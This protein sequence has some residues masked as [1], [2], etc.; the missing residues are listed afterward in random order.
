MHL[1]KREQ[2]EII[3]DTCSSGDRVLKGIS[4]LI[5]RVSK[6]PRHIFDD[7]R[8]TVP[9]QLGTE[10]KQCL[11]PEFLEAKLGGPRRGHLEVFYKKHRTHFKVVETDTSLAFKMAYGFA[12]LSHLHDEALATRILTAASQ[13]EKEY[14]GIHPHRFDADMLAQFCQDM[15]KAQYDFD[16]RFEKNKVK[17]EHFHRS[18]GGRSAD[19]LNELMKAQHKISLGRA[20]KRFFKKAPEEYRYLLQAMY[21]DRPLNMAIAKEPEFQK[22]RRDKGERAIEDFLFDKRSESDAGRVTVI[23]SEDQGARRSIEHLRGRS[24]N[25]VFCVS[26]YGL[27]CALKD[28][29]KIDDI[30]EVITPVQLAALEARQVRRDGRRSDNSMRT[31]SDV[32]D[33]DIERKW[34]KR[35]AEVVKWG[36]YKHTLGEAA[37]FSR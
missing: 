26:T 7:Y 18:L 27:A 4:K 6:D 19:A 16:E 9:I 17:I 21:S 37:G 35:L 30:H 11:F 28:L 25:T 32:L 22:F 10:S 12:A 3:V 2:F 34:A 1:Q 36:N 24:H 31:M 33:M 20:G 14:N 15:Q 13:L 8:I 5:D 29:K 23:V